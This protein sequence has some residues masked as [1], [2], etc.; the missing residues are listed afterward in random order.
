MFSND[1]KTKLSIFVLNLFVL[2]V[3]AVQ[4][5]QALNNGIGYVA[6]VSDSIHA[7]STSASTAALTAINDGTEVFADFVTAGVTKAV[8]GSKVAYDTAIGAAIKTKGSSLTLSE[9]QSQINAVNAATAAASLAAINQG[10]EV[11]ADF[12][13]AG[14]SKAISGEKAAYDT[15]IASAK[16]AKESDLTL[17]EVQSQINI[18]NAATAAASLAAI[19]QGTEVFADFSIA[20]VSKAI[21]GEKAA[22]D[23]AIAS[24]KMAKESD[25]TQAEVQSQINAVNAA[26]AAASLAA[27]NQGTEVFADFS[28]AGVSKA[29]SGEKAA[30]D[31]AIASAKM[32]KRSDLTLSEVQTQIDTLNSAAAATSLKAINQGKE[33]F[34]DFSTAGI[35]KAVVGNK[36][37]YDS[38]IASAKLYKGSSL[39]LEEV[40]TQVVGVNASVATASLMAINA[41]TEIFADFSTAGISKAVVGNKAAYDTAVA[42]NK[43]AKGSDLTLAE[44]QTQVEAV[45]TSASSAS[46]AAIN[47]GTEIFADFPTAGVSK[48]IAGDKTAYDT[49]IASAKMAKGSDLTLAEVQTQVEAVNTS[50]SSASLAAINAGTEI[51]ADFPTAGVSK[52]IA[53]DKAA[54]DTTIAS[55]KMT[56]GSDLTLAE[57][58]IQVEAVNTAAATTSLAAINAGTEAFTDF[59]TAGV[60]KAIGAN[61]VGY[62]TAI[63]MASLTKGSS[64]TLA[65]VQTQVE[66]VNSA[67]TTASLTAINA[68]TE[69]FTDF[70]TA[71]ITKALVTN[72]AGY[73]TTIA[74]AKKLKGSSLTLAEVQIQVNAVNTAA[75][76][77]SLAAINARAEVFA[78]FSTAGVTKAVVANNAD[79]DSAIAAAIITKGSSLTLAEVQ[80]QVEAVNSVAA[81]ASLVAINAGTEIFANFPIAG[82]TKAIIANKASYDT[83]IASAILTKASSLSLTEVQ[84]QVDTVNAAAATASLAAINAGTEIFADFS[85]AGITKTS[86]TY[87]AGYDT[88]IAAAIKTKGSNLTMSEVQT[89]VND[90]N[91]ATATASL[92]AIN[93]GT[94]VFADFSLAGVS[95]PIVANKA[96]YDAAIATA[97]NTKRSNLTLI[98]VQN[99]VSTIN[100]AVATASLAAVNAGTEVFADFSSAGVSRAVVK[101]KVSYDTAI[102]AAIRTKGSSLTLAEVQTQID[103][104]N[105]AIA[106]TALMAINGLASPFTNFA[107]AGV[108]GAILKNKLAYDNA[109][110]TAIKM[111]GS[112]LTLAEVQTQVNKVNGTG[113]LTALSAIN[114]GI[115]VFS[116][117]A[118]AGITG[119]VLKNKVAYDNAISAAI[120]IKNSDLT[121]AEI[122]R[123]VEGVNTEGTSTALLAINGGI[124]VFSDFATAGVK[125][126]I[127]NNKIAYDRAII[128]AINTKNSSLTLA[129][130]QALVDSVN[131]GGTTTALTAINGGVDVFSDFTTAGVKGAVLNNKIAYDRAISAAIKTKG[132]SLTLAEVQTQVS[133][134]NSP[135]Q[136]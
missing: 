105:A 35:S 32:A 125:G 136:H 73:D 12:S 65:E 83:A 103:S 16:M 28:T 46:L 79:Y 55:A 100:A 53:G 39:T 88:A 38:A 134:V 22:Y 45:N 115:D 40:Q 62:D 121:L 111:K 93:A 77:T 118:T 75:A 82:I 131:M 14:V 37:A 24:A 123:Q 57:V 49:A 69:V 76:T 94:E 95:R 15:A 13:T 30:Y 9:V 29:I 54:Y 63:A 90:I 109:I 8:V 102:A 116:D 56:K 44:V 66:A 17:A 113:A 72:N 25:L 31:T 42:S 129:E 81:A 124:D 2:N 74:L 26:A 64:L 34:V 18:V 99:Q 67:V 71:G 108:T 133:L 59:S 80:T 96:G 92:A 33:I 120:S 106:K 85:I 23:T 61:K 68:G 4:P 101:S 87:K 47:A 50:A 51:F 119:A 127:L 3:L 132:S 117:F 19:N 135:A 122:Q 107:K 70:S 36:A 60:T 110:T 114:G 6:V 52:A 97:L 41:G 126:A 7:G 112:S 1:N 20:G 104:F 43:K 130:V 58:Q 10:T 84:A 27:I 11:F 5:V 89:L 98:E 91:T 128:Q 78:D 21:S 86:V 48:A